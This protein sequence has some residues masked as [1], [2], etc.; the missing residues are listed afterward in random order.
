M[1]KYQALIPYLSK[2]DDNSFYSNFGPLEQELKDRMLAFAPKGSKAVATAA[3]ATLAIQGLLTVNS[4]TGEK[5]ACPSWT[6]AASAAAVVGANK[7]PMFKDVNL[8]TWQLDVSETEQDALLVAAF[9]NAVIDADFSKQHSG[10]PIVIDA[11]ASF[12]ALG[13]M[14]VPDDRAWAMVVSLHATKLLG[15][16]EGAIIFSN[17]ESWLRDFSSWTNFGFWGSRESELIGTNAKLSEYHSAVALASLDA[18]DETRSLLSE[19]GQY[20]LSSSR[21]LQVN[22]HPAME[23]GRLTPYWILQLPNSEVKVQ[24]QYELEK[25]GISYRDWWSVGVS[26]MPAFKTYSSTELKNTKYIASTTIGLPFYIGLKKS[27]VDQIT[28]ALS[29]MIYRG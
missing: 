10:S 18:W 23:Q 24:F 2:I 4:N 25:L 28:E 1:P 19:M 29:R 15:A 27:V 22:C 14:Q 17:D 26:E 3:N 11:A 9:G 20:C 12:A 5:I 16:G 13:S 21:E 6:F 8:G 7:T